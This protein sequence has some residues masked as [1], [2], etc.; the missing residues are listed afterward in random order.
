VL[1]GIDRRGL[2]LSPE[3]RQYLEILREKASGSSK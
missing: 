1:S 3:D 2:H